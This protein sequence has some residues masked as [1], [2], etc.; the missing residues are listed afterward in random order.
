MAPATRSERGRDLENEYRSRIALSVESDV[1]GYGERRRRFVDTSGECLSDQIS[2]HRSAARSSGSIDIASGQ[3]GLSQGGGTV[4]FVDTPACQSRRKSNH[5]RT[6]R[7]SN[8]ARYN[9]R[10]GVSDGG[11]S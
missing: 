10:T 8:I 3:G 7:D 4:R 1:P 9:G 11:S 2:G 5:G 6:W